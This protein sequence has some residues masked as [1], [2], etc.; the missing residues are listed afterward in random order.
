ML[1]SIGPALQRCLLPRLVLLNPVLHIG[2]EILQLGGP[3]SQD[4]RGCQGT[5]L[6][7]KAYK[8]SPGYSVMSSG[9]VHAIY[10]ESGRSTSHVEFRLIPRRNSHCLMAHA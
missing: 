2:A 7:E 6:F 4:G 5:V 10:R 9:A 8:E 1:R 3:S